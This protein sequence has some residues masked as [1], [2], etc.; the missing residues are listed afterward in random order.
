[1]NILSTK[2]HQREGIFAKFKTEEKK[3]KKRKNNREAHNKEEENSN[4]EENGNEETQEA[5]ELLREAMI[6]AYMPD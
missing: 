2:T 3:K 1:M 6:T 5:Q 4:Q